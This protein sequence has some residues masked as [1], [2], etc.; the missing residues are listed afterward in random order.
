VRRPVLTA[1]LCCLLLTA[2]VIAF[3]LLTP[4]AKARRAWKDTSIGGISAFVA[5][6]SRLT[7]EIASLSAR[8]TRY[9]EDSDTWLSPRLILMQNGDWI[10]Y[11]N[12]CQKEERRIR[13][14]FLGR[15]SDGQWYYSTYHFCKGMIV[16]RMDEQSENL[17]EFARKYHLRTFD[18]RSDEC[19]Q[20][21]WPIR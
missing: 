19:L 14:L 8:G 11:S 9:A 15:G 5:D 20:Q 10:A 12:I 21:T 18:G 7:N 4:S 13:D 3:T 6:P 17:P 1:V 16:L 2:L